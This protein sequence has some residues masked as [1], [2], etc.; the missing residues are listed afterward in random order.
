MNRYA[1]IADRLIIVSL[2]AVAVA[3]I[4]ICTFIVRIQP[5]RFGIIIDRVVILLLLRVGDSAVVVS[6]IVFAVPRDCLVII[7][8]G[9]LVLV[10]PSV[11]QP[12]VIVGVDEIRVDAPNN[13]LVDVLLSPTGTSSVTTTGKLSEASGGSQ[14][15]AGVPLHVVNINESLTIKVPLSGTALHRNLNAYA[16]VEGAYYSFGGPGTAD[17]NVSG[18]LSISTTTPFASVN[19]GAVES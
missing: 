18:S 13:P 10:K 4:E 11:H 19:R 5:N 8:N 16:R 3:A 15:S 14:W 9:L 17:V 6:K 2:S 7:L 12:S 1:I